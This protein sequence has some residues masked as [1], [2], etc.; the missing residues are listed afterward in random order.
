MYKNGCG[1]SLTHFFDDRC[2]LYKVAL[3]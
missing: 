3:K 1:L 2:T